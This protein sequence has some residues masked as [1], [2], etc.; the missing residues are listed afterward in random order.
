[1]L[2][3]AALVFADEASEH[4]SERI[5]QLGDTSFQVREAAAEELL[6][7]GMAAKPALTL[8]MTHPDLEI[9]L[10]VR[11]LLGSIEQNELER[12][13]AAFLKDTKDFDKYN[14]PGWA[15]FSKAVGEDYTS[16]ELFA[17]ILRA[18]MR[19]LTAVQ[20]DAKSAAVL[21]AQ[22]IQSLQTGSY[23]GTPSRSSVASLAA[24]LLVGG[25]PAMSLNSV[26]G[27][28][29]YSLLQQSQTGR[30]ITSGKRSPMI[31]KL[32]GA[33]LLGQAEN[34]TLARNGLLLALRYQMKEA[35]LQLAGTLLEKKVTSSS[36]ASTQGY[37]ILT[38]GRFGDHGNVKQ[39][40]AMLEND[41]V[42]HSW[43]NGKFKEAIR[44][45][46][47]DVALAVLIHLTGQEHKEYGFQLIRKSSTTLFSIYTCGFPEESKRRTALAKWKQWSMEQNG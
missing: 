22:R 42:C 47:R 5:E 6:K 43:H 2:L 4:L 21:Y 40:E 9:R 16:R 14:F 37:A 39:L 15:Q 20:R 45:Q 44:V 33:W 26:G 27:Y 31:R 7:L 38:I 46:I 41:T 29:M 28:Q 23:T 3:F 24:L 12:R 17:E 19:L 13:V 8:A 35:G 25:D 30:A 36:L 32:F 34:P 10:R 18:E 11:H 1:M